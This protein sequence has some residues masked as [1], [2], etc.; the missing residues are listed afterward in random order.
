MVT[1]Y[2]LLIKYIPLV[3]LLAI[4]FLLKNG[5]LV[6]LAINWV[7]LLLIEKKDIRVLGL[8]PTP[9]T[10]IQLPVGFCIAAVFCALNYW[11]QTLFSGSVWTINA[12]FTLSKFLSG[13]WWTMQSVLYEELIFRAALLYIAIQKIGEKRAIW[14]SAICFGIYHWFSMGAFGNWIVMAYLFI[15][16]GIMGYIFAL[17]YAKTKSLY[18]PI[19]LHFGWNLVNNIVFSQGPNGNQLLIIKRGDFLNMTESII[20][21]LVQFVAFPLVAFLYI[22]MLKSNENKRITA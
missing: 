5:L 11:V 15:G 18:L 7:L 1:K 14:L 8:F 3:V 4:G 9:R 16:T 2:P 20:V 19:G 6:E 12:S 21:M 10:T 22:K 17:A 13:S